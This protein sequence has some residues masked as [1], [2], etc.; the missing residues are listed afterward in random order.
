MWCQWTTNQFAYQLFFQHGD[1]LSSMNIWIFK[2]SNINEETGVSAYENI[3]VHVCVIIY[4]CCMLVCVRACM[5]LY[6][7]NFLMFNYWWHM[8]MCSFI[9]HCFFHCF[10]SSLVKGRTTPL[11]NS[12]LCQRLA[13]VLT[14]IFACMNFTHL[15]RLFPTK[16]FRIQVAIAFAVSRTTN[17]N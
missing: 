2:Q 6:V 14:E 10:V 16:K 9:R 5:C 3:N 1:T 8:Y 7:T 11:S 12:S 15:K 17:W 4:V 13:F